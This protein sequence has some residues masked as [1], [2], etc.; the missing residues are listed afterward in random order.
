MVELRADA[1]SDAVRVITAVCVSA[2]AAAV[3]PVPA[4]GAAVR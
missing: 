2:V 1:S 4:A 3:A